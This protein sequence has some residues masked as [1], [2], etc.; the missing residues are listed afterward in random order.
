MSPVGAKLR[1]TFDNPQRQIFD[2][3]QINTQH[4]PK[5]I[6]GGLCR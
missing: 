2:L 5:Q 3:E 4:Q 1:K 6:F